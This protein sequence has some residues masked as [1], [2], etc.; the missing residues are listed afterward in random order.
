MIDAELQEKGLVRVK[1]SKKAEECFGQPLCLPRADVG[2]D[3]T[4][5]VTNVGT[6]PQKFVAVFLG[7]ADWP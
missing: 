1:I 7:D 3:V 2:T 4:I 6:K 5:Y